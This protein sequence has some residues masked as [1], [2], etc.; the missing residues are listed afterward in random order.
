MKVFRDKSSPG[1]LDFVRTRL[2][3][4]ASQGLGNHRRILRLDRDCLEGGLAGFD[5]FV[6]TG[7]GAACSDCGDQYIHLAVGVGPN[8]LGGGF[9]VNGG[10]CRV[11]KLLGNP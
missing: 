3:R 11:V 8:F 4:L 6:A 5:H 9:A 7:D 1:A 2:D 10:V